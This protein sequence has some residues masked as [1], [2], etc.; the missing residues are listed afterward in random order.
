MQI[1]MFYNYK[2]VVRYAILY[3]HMYMY[4]KHTNIIYLPVYTIPQ[5]ITYQ[6]VVRARI[7]SNEAHIRTVAGR[8]QR[9]A[10]IRNIVAGTS[11]NAL[12]T[13][14][15]SEVN[16]ASRQSLLQEAGIRVSEAEGL[17]LKSSL[18]IPWNK[19]RHIRR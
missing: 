7:P 6:R 15:T 8:S 4:N 3:V 14:L 12:S 16:R 2:R 11:S 18:A 17:A 19:L 13:Q 1:V 5:P 9:M 10:E